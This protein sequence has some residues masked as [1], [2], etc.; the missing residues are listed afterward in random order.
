MGR[1]TGKVN[2]PLPPTTTIENR[3][4]PGTSGRNLLDEPALRGG[5]C[6]WNEKNSDG[7]YIVYDPL[8]I[9]SDIPDAEEYPTLNEHQRR[10][11]AVY[12]AVRK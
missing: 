2:N 8:D 6:R 5:T 11:I 4:L 12:E 10:G 7:N 1:N 3:Y 9:N